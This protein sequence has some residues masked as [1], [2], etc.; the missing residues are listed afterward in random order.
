MKKLLSISVFCAV[1]C[2]L[3]LVSC[4]KEDRAAK[5]DA[6]M[7]QVIEKY[8]NVG[9][10]VAVVKDGEILYENRFGYKNLEAK[11]PIETGDIFRI[12]SISKSFVA[13][14][15]MQLVEAGK[16][17]LDDD[18]SDLIGFQVRNPKFPDQVITLKMILSHTSSMSDAGGYFSLDPIN[19]AVT[20]DSA[21]SFN[22]WAPGEN[23]QYC[24]LGYNLA[25]TILEKAS[26]VRFDHYVRQNIFDK[27]GLYGG[28]N[29]ND[30]DA[31][32]FVT[33]Y[34]MEDDKL[35]EQPAAYRNREDEMGAYVMGYSTPIFSPTG[36]VKI[37][38]I[39][40]AKYM[41][42][43]IQKGEYNGTRIISPESSALM[44]SLIWNFNETTGYG[45]GLNVVDDFVPGMALNGHTGSAYG[46]FSAMYFNPAE[47]W[48]IVVITNGLE[49]NA[50]QFQRESVNELYTAL[51]K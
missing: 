33:I 10:A 26:G 21:P 4:A 38:A 41:T 6:A 51:I 43:H 8:G 19:P 3:L 50:R 49:G 37:S 7:Q 35:V 2:S 29:I 40:L 5:A 32:K 13:T 44:Q 23:Y 48:G 34:E 47:N 24:N 15:L 12:A 28:H 1:I 30:L 18:V 31:S 46:L 16:L 20:Q 42:M 9:V 11:T 14:S 36:G 27:L 45:L 22:D 17:S 25:G 39:D